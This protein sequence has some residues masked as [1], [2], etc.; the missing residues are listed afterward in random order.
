VNVAK[1]EPNGS[2]AI[3]PAAEAVVFSGRGPRASLCFPGAEYRFCVTDT[4]CLTTINIVRN[5]K[6]RAWA[7]NP[8]RSL[9]ERAVWALAVGLP[10]KHREPAGVREAPTLRDLGD[11]GRRPVGG[12]Q[13]I[14]GA[15]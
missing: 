1:P 14:M 2:N 8:L 10:V 12:H 6:L 15:M 13:V 9:S 11:R 7:D 3:R 5:A 4:L